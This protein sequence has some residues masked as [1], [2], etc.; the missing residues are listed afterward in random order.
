M[1]GANSDHAFTRNNALRTS[2]IRNNAAMPAT[3]D[4]PSLPM[5]AV[6]L[7][8]ADDRVPGISR[9]RAV[10]RLPARLPRPTRWLQPVERALIAFLREAD[11]NNTVDSR[12]KFR[13]D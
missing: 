7:I 1:N 11:T 12:N 3:H 5:P 10:N 13:P 2:H 4:L 8:Y 9:V 6:A